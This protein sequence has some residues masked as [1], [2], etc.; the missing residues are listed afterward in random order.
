ML[1][2]LFKKGLETDSMLQVGLLLYINEI[3]ESLT[4]EK[5]TLLKSRIA[6]ISDELIA[7]EMPIEEG[8]GKMRFFSRDTE[9]TAF[10]VSENGMKYSFSSKVTGKASDNIPLLL[11]EKPMESSITKTQRRD[12]LRVP[13]NLN[14]VIILQ[15]PIEIVNVQTI[16]LSGGGLSFSSSK[17]LPL[18]KGQTVNGVLQLPEKK[19]DSE[20]IRFLG[21]VKRATPPD[22]QRPIQTV[23]L[24]FEDIEERDRDK[25]IQLC[26]HRELELNRK[27]NNR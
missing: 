8:T 4:E 1:S 12:Y 20:D 7:I 18:Q 16:D 3:S 13:M 11:I 25:I 2:R 26:I 19:K 17:T 15:N 5:D 10:F 22:E 27:Y 9:I 24:H 6:E 21:V 14:L 23:A